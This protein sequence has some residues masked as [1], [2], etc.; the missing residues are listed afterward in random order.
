MF[1]RKIED[2]PNY[3][4]YHSVPG[5]MVGAKKDFFAFNPAF[6]KPQ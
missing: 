6:Y 2:V 4:D 5:A 3:P 1:E